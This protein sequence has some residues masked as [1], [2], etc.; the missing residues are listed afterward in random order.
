MIECSKRHVK[1]EE[2][3]YY[4]EFERK[5]PLPYAKDGRVGFYLDLGAYARAH[6]ASDEFRRSVEEGARNAK[7]NGPKPPPQ[8]NTK[9]RRPRNRGASKP[10][11]VF[12]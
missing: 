10:L 5:G 12:T 4:G 2:C 8:K 1:A 3:P 9:P 6:G 7:R 11:E